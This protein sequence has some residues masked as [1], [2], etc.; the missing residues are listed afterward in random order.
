MFG[1][2]EKRKEGS[3]NKV[4]NFHEEKANNYIKNSVKLNNY[5]RFIIVGL[6]LRGIDDLVP[7]KFFSIYF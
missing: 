1:M 4:V 6:R 3:S 2:M 7:T 5:Q